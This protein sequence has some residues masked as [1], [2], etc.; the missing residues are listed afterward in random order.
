MLMRS[1]GLH[2][3]SRPK[4]N[5]TPRSAFPSQSWKTSVLMVLTLF[6][7][8]AHA[9][10]SRISNEIIEKILQQGVPPEALSKALEFRDKNM[11]QAFRQDTYICAGQA[12]DNVKPCDENKRTTTS[13]SVTVTNHPYLVI[14]DFRQSSLEQRMFV[15]QLSSGQVQRFK[16]THGIGSGNLFAYKFSNVKNSKQTSLGFYLTGESYPGSYGAT[17]R[18]Y[19]LQGSNDQ[20]YMRD[21]VMHGAWYAAEDFPVKINDT[22]GKPFGRLGL[23]W[24][25]PAVS[26]DHAKKL[27]PL[28]QGGAL[29]YHYQ[30]E[31]EEAAM[32]GKE[33]IGDNRE[34]APVEEI[35]I[36]KPRPTDSSLAPGN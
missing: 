7:V 29:L 16:V 30:P 5:S 21:I 10:E 1:F 19:G 31:L 23:S 35:P 18:L 8:Q 20:A 34:P 24:G 2:L 12:A 17:L 22:T 11:N 6:F 3:F 26:L 15:I 9:E 27:F 25:C 33:V 4:R 14:I 36:P 13:R 28:L 32:T